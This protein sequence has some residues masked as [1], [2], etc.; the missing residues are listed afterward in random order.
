MLPWLNSFTIP[1]GLVTWGPTLCFFLSLATSHPAADGEHI[2]RPLQCS[3]FKEQQQ[4]AT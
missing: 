2:E 3:R 1:L 4:I